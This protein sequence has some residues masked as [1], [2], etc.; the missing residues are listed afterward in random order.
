[1]TCHQEGD[2]PAL[3]YLTPYQDSDMAHR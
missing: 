2:D 1:M 3:A